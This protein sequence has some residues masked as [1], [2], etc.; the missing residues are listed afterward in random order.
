MLETLLSSC[1]RRL[2]GMGLVSS[3]GLGDAAA[4]DGGGG[5]VSS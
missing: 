3:C 5:G 1:A 4:I 2:F